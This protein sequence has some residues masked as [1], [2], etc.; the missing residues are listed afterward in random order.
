MS[1]N[2]FIGKFPLIQNKHHVLF[3]AT[4][5]DY[6]VPSTFLGLQHRSWRDLS[7]ATLAGRSIPSRTIVPGSSWLLVSSVC[8]AQKLHRHRKFRAGELCKEL[9]IS[10]LSVLL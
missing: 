2:D 3:V 9:F 1:Q 6:V 5:I 10:V 4:V 7:D 8:R